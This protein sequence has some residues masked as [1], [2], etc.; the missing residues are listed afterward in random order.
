MEKD[1]QGFIFN[2]ISAD[3]VAERKGKNLLKKSWKLNIVKG[4]KATPQKM[5]ISNWSDLSSRAI[6]I[7]NITFSLLI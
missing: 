5:Q 6:K 7:N 4:E 1:Y 2:K 3:V